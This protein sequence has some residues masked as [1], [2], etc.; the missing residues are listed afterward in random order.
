LPTVTIPASAVT[1]DPP[2]LPAGL[3]EYRIVLKDYRFIGSNF[4]GKIKLTT[5]P[6][7]TDAGLVDIAP[8]ETVVTVGL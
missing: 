5:A 1:F 2:F 6:I 7:S 8:D 3:T 4:T